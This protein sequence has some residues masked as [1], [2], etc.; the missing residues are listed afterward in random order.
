MNSN[1][2]LEL[3]KK[4]G[5]KI[6]NREAFKYLAG[7]IIGIFLAES[8]SSES[9]SASGDGFKCS[10]IKPETARPF[11]VDGSNRPNVLTDSAVFRLDISSNLDGTNIQDGA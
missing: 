2:Y 3:A 9:R 5:I 11:T 8:F 10:V 6:N 7:S 4:F 1:F